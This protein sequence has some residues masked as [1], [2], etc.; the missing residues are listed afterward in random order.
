LTAVGCR[1]GPECR[2]LHPSEDGHTAQPRGEHWTPDLD[3]AALPAPPPA[4]V[5]VVPSTNSRAVA[6]PTPRAQA[7]DPRTFQIAQ[8]ERRFKPESS[9]SSN[10]K[11]SLTFGLQP[12]DPD[13]PYEIESLQCVLHVPRTYPNGE[14]PTIEVTNNDIPRGFQINIEHGFDAIAAGS[15][16]STLLALLST[17]HDRSLW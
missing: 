7:E 5:P 8:V 15:P 17:C 16:T 1:A 13:F 10:G 9:T 12:S 14:L 3:P 2:F 4:R 11:T 6:R